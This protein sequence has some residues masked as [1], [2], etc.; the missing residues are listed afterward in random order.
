M[1]KDKDP[2]LEALKEGHSHTWTK[3]EGGNLASADNV[4]GH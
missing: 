2:L 3:P 1:S 4:A